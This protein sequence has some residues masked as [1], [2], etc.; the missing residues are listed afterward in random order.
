MDLTVRTDG[1][2]SMLAISGDLT[3]ESAGRLKAALME[4]L[5]KGDVSFDLS[6]AA[7]MDFSCFQ[8]LCSAHM[9]AAL[10]GKKLVI[11]TYSDSFAHAARQTGLFP[12]VCRKD[13][14]TSDHCLWTGFGVCC[15]ETSL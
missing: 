11:Q 5:E 1:C 12:G 8:V 4:A 6:G 10:S 7:Q 14:K 2:N 9:S 3:A 15:G 13:K